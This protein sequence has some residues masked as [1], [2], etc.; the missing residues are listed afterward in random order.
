LI[1]FVRLL[2]F[3]NSIHLMDDVRIHKRL[4]PSIKVEDEASPFISFTFLMNVCTI[5]TFIYLMF[6]FNSVI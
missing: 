3:M 2:V 5:P 6:Y 1:L 4:K